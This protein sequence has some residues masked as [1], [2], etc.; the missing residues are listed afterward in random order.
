MS[1][2]RYNPGGGGGVSACCHGPVLGYGQHT[3]CSFILYPGL[4]GWRHSHSPISVFAK[5]FRLNSAILK[6]GLLQQKL[7]SDEL[8]QS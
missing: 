4:L 3:F 5:L 2:K 6:A 7:R 8:V 1:I